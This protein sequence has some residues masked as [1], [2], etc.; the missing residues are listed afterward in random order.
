MT[1]TITVTCF[2]KFY[3]SNKKFSITLLLYHSTIIFSWHC[4]S[5]K[6]RHP[7][8]FS[9][10]TMTCSLLSPSPPP[11]L[12]SMQVMQ[13]STP[14]HLFTC[15]YH[16]HETLNTSLCIYHFLDGSQKLYQ[17]YKYLKIKSINRCSVSQSLP[18]TNLS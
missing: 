13:L 5:F 2:F 3:F 8:S 11:K 15:I 6:L 14:L 18:S 16:P 12:I 17:Q 7:S 9:S 4:V 1:I 10:T